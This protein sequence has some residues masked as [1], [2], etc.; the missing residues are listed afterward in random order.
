MF[1]L[2][3]LFS[4]VV[5]SAASIPWPQETAPAP[6][7]ADAAS[8]ERP[9]VLVPSSA[10]AV[11]LDLQSYSGELRFK[12]VLEHGSYVKSGDVIARFDLEPIDRMILDA[13][14]ELASTRMRHEH[15]IATAQ[16]DEEA[17]QRRRQLAAAERQRARDA[18]DGWLKFEKEFQK[19]DQERS[20]KYMNNNIEDQREELS[21]L[22]AM[23]REDE[24]TD[25]TEEIVLNRTRRDFTMSLENLELSRERRDYQEK[26]LQP[27]E[28]QRKKEQLED[29]EFSYQ[30]QMRTLDMERE[31]RQDSI[32]RGEEG[33]RKAEENLKKLH[34]DREKLTVR[35]RRAGMLLHGSVEQHG[36]GQ[37][38]PR[39]KAERSTASARVE[40]FTIADSDRFKVLLDVPEGMVTRLTQNMAVNV[41][42]VAGGKCLV[43]A[44]KFDRFPAPRGMS[45]PENVYEAWVDLKD[46]MLGIVPGMRAKVSF[47]EGSLSQS[48]ESSG[49]R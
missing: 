10:E 28:E 37:V 43:G 45:G 2:A 40:L 16:M 17:A 8:I 13:Q 9:G 25:A 49:S 5:V 4:P 44:L 32:K 20:M 42:L 38:P 18:Y 47:A 6:T 23:Y 29:Q 7:P 22:E 30:R 24:L 41:T 46:T 21:Q 35:A 31:Q 36:P 1:R 14:M 27:V 48:P 12:E 3:L 39:Y 26:L 15:V 19:R 11:L 33:L 34:A